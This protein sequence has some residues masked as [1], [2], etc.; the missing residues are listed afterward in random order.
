MATYYGPTNEDFRTIMLERYFL[1][2]DLLVGVGYGGPPFHCRTRLFLLI[3]TEESRHTSRALCRLRALS[4]APSQSA[5][6]LRSLS[7][8]LHHL[9]LRHPVHLCR[10][11]GS[12]CTADVCRQSQ[13]PW[14]AMDIL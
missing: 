1:A 6:D 4:L 7:A 5:K 3:P 12:N 2:G 14:R 9:D 11:T 10:R 13:L 8:S